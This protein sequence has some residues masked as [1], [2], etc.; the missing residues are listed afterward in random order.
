M[1]FLSTGQVEARPVLATLLHLV[2]HSDKDASMG[3]LEWTLRGF[4]R[5]PLA[6]IA[7]EIAMRHRDT[8]WER[9]GPRT[10]GMHPAEARGYLYARV[11]GLVHREVDRVL[12][13]HADLRPTDREPLV[14]LARTALV[15]RVMLELQLRQMLAVPARRAA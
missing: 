11:A 12:R 8:I 6:D 9:V 13:L 4:S 15:D 3:W 2:A 1:L 14:R 5:R 7:G 10:I